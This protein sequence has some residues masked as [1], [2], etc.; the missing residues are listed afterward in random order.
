MLRRAPDNHAFSP[1]NPGT[2]GRDISENAT[3]AG[4]PL[5]CPECNQYIPEMY[6]T[7]C[8]FQM[9]L[10]D[11]I[12]HALPAQRD[13]HF[14][15]FIADYEYI[16]S[17]EGRGIQDDRFYL[18]LPYRDVSGR[19][20]DQWKIRAKSFDH[21]CRHVLHELSDGD[22]I[23]DLGAGN[24]WM[25]YQLL[26]RGLF[27]VAVDLLTNPADGLGAAVH[28]E[29]HLQLSIPRF[30]A[31]LSNLPFQDKHFDAAIF[32]ASFHYAEDACRAVSEALRC[33]KPGGIVVIID[34]PWYSCEESGHAMVEERKRQFLAR[35]QNSS[36]SIQSVEFLTDERLRALEQALGIR[37]ST[38][39]PW[40]G[41]KWALRPLRAALKQR[42]EPSRFR[43]YVARR[44]SNAR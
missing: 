23:L 6:C 27:P 8:G 44:D 9:E 32:N 37:W 39:R 24:C 31:E 18:A 35:Y 16:R 5:R 25:S 29:N 42:R 34:T 1:E 3:F 26:R 13:S 11:G 41:F 33:L 22:R 28:F 14:A 2:A 21:L 38:Y 30:R 10:R 20:G 17:Q 36:D 43:I 12:V 15:Q 19:N 40:Y 4:I 7:R